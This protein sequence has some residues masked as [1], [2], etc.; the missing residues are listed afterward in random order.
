[1]K[2]TFEFTQTIALKMTS[3][4]KVLLTIFLLNSIECSGE[5]L[6]LKQAEE[7]FSKR[8]KCDLSGKYIRAITVIADPF[9]TIKYLPDLDLDLQ[10]YRVTKIASGILPDVIENLALA[11]NFS[12]DIYL[13]KDVTHYGTVRD[14]EANNTVEIS[15]LFAYLLNNTGKLNIFVF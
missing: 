12:Y 14:I 8:S 9:M 11:C 15:G 1:M 6:T 13:A 10:A 5:V 7:K 4:S 3:I 2:C